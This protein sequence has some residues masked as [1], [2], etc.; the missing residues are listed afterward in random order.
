PENENEGG[1]SET[2]AKETSESA[3]PLAAPAGFEKWNGVAICALTEGI[4]VCV[5][6]K[7]ER[8]NTGNQTGTRSR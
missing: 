8:L 5:R 1:F 4:I 2:V 7:W 6:G 3:D